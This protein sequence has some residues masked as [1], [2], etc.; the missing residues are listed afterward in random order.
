MLS[1]QTAS[2]N[3]VSLDSEIWTVRDLAA[4]LKCSKRSVYELTRRRG[5]TCHEVPLP[6]SRLP[7]GMRFLRRDVEVEAW[8]RQ[9]ADVGKQYQS[10]RSIFIEPSCAYA[11][12]VLTLD[13]RGRF[14]LRIRWRPTPEVGVA[15]R[16][17]RASLGKAITPIWLY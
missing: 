12:A 1:Q 7:C 11:C 4:F 15:R 6:V 3:P 8:F 16:F 2:S 10:N 13:T 9:C 5:Q 17:G 14:R